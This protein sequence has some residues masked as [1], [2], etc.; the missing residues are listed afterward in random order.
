MKNIILPE[1]N[2]GT[3]IKFTEVLEVVVHWGETEFI[4]TFRVFG[5][6]A[7]F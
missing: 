1:A 5:N 4:E 3:E 7:N 2:Y 6:S